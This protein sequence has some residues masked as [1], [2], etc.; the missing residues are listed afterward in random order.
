VPARVA[1]RAVDVPQTLLL[2]VLDHVQTPSRSARGD[3]PPCPVLNELG[4]YLHR[5]QLRPWLRVEGADDALGQYTLR[6]HV[7]VGSGFGLQKVCKRR[8]SPTQQISNLYVYT[9][10]SPG[11]GTS[12]LWG[13]E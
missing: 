11:L 3:V 5:G 7:L 10:A 4:R 12:S 6:D 8:F 13:S 2:D 1:G 9:H